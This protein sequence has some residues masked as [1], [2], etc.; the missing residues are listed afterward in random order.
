MLVLLVLVMGPAPGDASLWPAWG[1]TSGRTTVTITGSLFRNTQFLRCA[2]GDITGV[3]ATFM[4]SSQIKC[5]SPPHAAGT[6]ALEVSLND[7]DYTSNGA[8]YTYQVRCTFS[9]CVCS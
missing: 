9:C 7:Q 2:F 4:S 3:Y 1:P 5:I 8:L 6:V